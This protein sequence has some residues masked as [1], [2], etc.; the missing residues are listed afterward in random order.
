[1][2][3]VQFSQIVTVGAFLGLL[4]VARWWVGQ[5]RG[6]I[7]SRL[8]P[9]RVLEVQEVLALGPHER[10]S[11]IRVGEGRILVHSSR[12]AAAVVLTMPPEP[13]IAQA[14][15]ITLCNAGMK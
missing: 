10:L 4:M 5:R 8:R 6:Q 1:M 14:S 7:I 13:A 15:E 9:G 11:L 3:W 2:E 12:G